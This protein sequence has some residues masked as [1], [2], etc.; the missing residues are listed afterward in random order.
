LAE[1]LP[2]HKLASC[3]TVKDDDGTGMGANADTTLNVLDNKMMDSFMSLCLLLRYA[4]LVVDT[5]L[6]CLY[7]EQ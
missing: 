6:D 5:R 4:I 1:P 2:I 3:A 7:I